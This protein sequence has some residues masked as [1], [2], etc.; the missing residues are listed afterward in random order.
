MDGRLGESRDGRLGES[1]AAARPQ[2]WGGS[3]IN[4]LLGGEC[5]TA[6]GMSELAAWFGMTALD[7][8]MALSGHPRQNL[9]RPDGGG[10]FRCCSASPFDP[11]ESQR[12]N[13]LP[14]QSASN[15]RALLSNRCLS[16]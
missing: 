5:N 11:P 6:I 7:T 10:R 1:R 12:I 3:A 13:V 9:G 16:D 15:L 4:L 14:R 2:H 8:V